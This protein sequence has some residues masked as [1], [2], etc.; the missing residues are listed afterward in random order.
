MY[1]ATTRVPEGYQTLYMLL[2]PFGGLLESYKNILVRGLPPSHYV[3]VA[4]VMAVVVFMVG[5]WYFTRDEY[6]LVKAI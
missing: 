4:A 2:N 3:A 6:K 5:L 1:T